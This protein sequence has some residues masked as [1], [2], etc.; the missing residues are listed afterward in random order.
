MIVFILP[1]GFGSKHQGFVFRFRTAYNPADSPDNCHPLYALR[2][3]SE[4]DRCREDTRSRVQTFSMISGL[5]DYREG[6]SLGK[7]RS[8]QRTMI[9]EQGTASGELS[10]RSDL[11]HV[12]DYLESV[13]V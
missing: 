11:I 7:G 13:L 1:E 3:S 5:T 6:W 2:S 10:P 4:V 8:R 9:S 12:Q